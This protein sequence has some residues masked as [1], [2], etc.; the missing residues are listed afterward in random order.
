VPQAGKVEG[1][2]PES[3][4]A[5]YYQEGTSALVTRISFTGLPL[6]APHGKMT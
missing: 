5:P 1:P 4:E 6:P 3:V 2:H